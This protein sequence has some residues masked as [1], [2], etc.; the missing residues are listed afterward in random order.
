[1]L[2]KIKTTTKGGCYME[3]VK[4]GGS[5][6]FMLTCLG[7]EHHRTVLMT[8][9]LCHYFTSGAFINLKTAPTMLPSA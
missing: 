3:T 4:T 2:I 9:C 6:M 5:S 1:M 7:N 8:L